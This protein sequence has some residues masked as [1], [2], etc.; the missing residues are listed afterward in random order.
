MHGIM[1][2]VIET[3]DLK[4]LKCLEYLK[5]VMIFPAKSQEVANLLFNVARCNTVIP[6]I[7]SGNIS[8][9]HKDGLSSN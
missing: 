2:P 1:K 7:K 4:H 6:D 3:A 5:P 8:S 9:E